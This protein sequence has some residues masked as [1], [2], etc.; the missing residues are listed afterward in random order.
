ME[1]EP[2]AHVDAAEELPVALELGLHDPVGRGR[3]E[4]LEELVQLP[5]AEDRQ[6]HALVEVAPATVDA[7]ALPHQR[8]AAI[9]AHDVLRT[10]HLAGYVLVGL[11]LGVS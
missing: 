11:L 3:R 2:L 7:H 10:Y 9:T 1:K 4:A 6:H 8:L 5:R